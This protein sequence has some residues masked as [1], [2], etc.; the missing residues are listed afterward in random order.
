MNWQS[1]ISVC[2]STLPVG[3]RPTCDWLVVGMLRAARLAGG[4]PE[5][6]ILVVNS[7]D[8]GSLTIANQYIDLRKIPACNVVYLDWRG[9]DAQIDINTFRDKIL[10][11]IVS[12]IEKRNLS[13]QI[14]GIIYSSKFPW[15]I[16]FRED[17]PQDFVKSK[18]LDPSGVSGSSPACGSLNGL[19]Y[20]YGPV[21]AKDVADYGSLTSNHY[22]RL[23]DSLGGST[24]E[25]LQVPNSNK[26][27]N[28]MILP[29]AQSIPQCRLKTSL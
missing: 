3:R 12:E 2:R 5:N 15:R 4:G 19:T 27:L 18:S 9:G 25:M 6:M 22:M 14:D 21:L 29:H 28:G 24:L 8:P 11:P 17:V 16:D 20:L 26:V 1:K 23:F 13:A 10:R 7:S